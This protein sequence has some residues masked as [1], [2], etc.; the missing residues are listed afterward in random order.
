MTLIGA[1]PNVII[2]GRLAD[3]IG[4]TDFVINLAPAVL[5][6]MPIVIMFLKYKF[7]ESLA[8]TYP[9]QMD[10]LYERYKIKDIQLLV[11]AGTVTIFVI[12]AFFLHPVHHRSS[13]WVA[14]IGAMAILSVGASKDVSKVLHHVEWDTLLFFGGLFVLVAALSELGLIREIGNL[15]ANIV[16]SAAPDARLGVACVTIL[17]ISAVVSGFLSN[18]AFAA[19]M[20][21]VIK[22]VGEDTEL[23]L[24]MAPL[25]WSLAFG[26]C[27]GGNLTLIGSAA[28][29]IA[30]GVAQHNGM[31]ISF[32]AFF[33]VGGPVWVI[34]NIIA[35]FWLLA[36]YVWS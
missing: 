36:A 2:G 4:F 29:L 25:A 11:R 35:M 33:K 1:I 10:I 6:M 28:N 14:L 16:K 19:T 13:G 7:R 17:W 22:I 32:M 3:Y 18:I 26:T 9:V 15:I 20:A 24:P 31:H 8:G 30:A 21:P 27:L 5:I 12:I 34:T 23:N